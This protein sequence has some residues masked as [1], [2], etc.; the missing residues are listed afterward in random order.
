MR[1]LVAYQ[2]INRLRRVILHFDLLFLAL[3]P[4]PG[5]LSTVLSFLLSSDR[6]LYAPILTG[7]PSTARQKVYALG[8]V[9]H[10]RVL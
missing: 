6:S 10:V 4:D 5:A 7:D 1:L 3:V 9:K 8:L 2:Q